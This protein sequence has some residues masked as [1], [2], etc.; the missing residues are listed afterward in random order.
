MSESGSVFIADRANGRDNN[1]NLIR[2]IAA[3]SVLVSHAYPISYGPETSEPLSTIL[4]GKTL[5]GF[6]VMVFFAIS[7]FFIARSFARKSSPVAFFQARALRLFPA[8][9]IALLV[10]V[11]FAAFLTTAP[12]PEYWGAVPEHLLRNV[13][14][15]RLQYDLPGVFENNPYAPAI[16]GSL[17]TLKYE[18]LCYLGVVVF[19]IAGLTT[20]PRLFALALMIFVGI[21]LTGT[22]FHLHPR[23]EEFLTLALPFATGMAFWTWRDQIRLSCRFVMI[24]VAFCVLTWPTPVFQPVL[25]ITASYAVFVLGYARIPG[26][27]RYNRLGDYSYGMYIYAFPIQQFIAST[28]I[29]SP[30]VSIAIAFPITLILAVTSWHLIEAPALG[31]KHPSRGQAIEPAVLQQ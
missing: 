21:Y 8:L 17:W 11:F 28:G 26:A 5:G 15:F 16:N 25:A 22:G 6:S 24:G 20:R 2:M 19:G 1:F 7:G 30:L 14:L 23:I 18:V 12:A 13:T 3:T 31:W 4:Q 10:T 29:T 9:V 27:A